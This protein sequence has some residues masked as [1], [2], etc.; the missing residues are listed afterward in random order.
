MR[1]EGGGWVECG[2]FG[3][4]GGEFEE[5]GHRYVCPATESDWDAMGERERSKVEVTRGRV[6]V[7]I[8]GQGSEFRR[9]H[10]ML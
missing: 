7:R 9:E 3:E 4:R 10:R 2:C 6:R 5:S 8:D 1:A